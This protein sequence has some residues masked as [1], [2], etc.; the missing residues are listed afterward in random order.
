[1]GLL[2]LKS[3]LWYNLRSV[4][5]CSFIPPLLIN[6]PDKRKGVNFIYGTFFSNSCEFQLQSH[7]VGGGGE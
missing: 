4:V 7:Y 3:L 2:R 5:F 6:I 1:M